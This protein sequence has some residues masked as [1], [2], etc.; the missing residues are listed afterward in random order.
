MKAKTLT[1]GNFK[2][3]GLAKKHLFWIFQLCAA[4]S[5]IGSTITYASVLSQVLPA[6]F[7]DTFGILVGDGILSW[8]IN[9]VALA[10]AIGIAV[11]SDYFFFSVQ[12]RAGLTEFIIMAKRY[13]KEYKARLAAY[14]SSGITFTRCVMAF[15]YMLFGATGFAASFYTSYSSQEIVASV[16]RP[17]AMANKNSK[18]VAD[19]QA[20]MQASE[21]EYT[22]DLSRKIEQR[23][24]DKQAFLNE[25]IN[26]RTKKQIAA[27]NPAALAFADS[28]N[29]VAAKEFD[30]SKEQAELDKAKSTWESQVKPSF[31]KEFSE[32]YQNGTMRNKYADMIGFFVMLLGVGACSG[33]LGIMIVICLDDVDNMPFVV[34]DYVGRKIIRLDKKESKEQSE[35]SAEQPRPSQKTSSP[36]QNGSG[37]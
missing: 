36:K 22:G 11:V 16:A 21:L 9:F 14:Q 19:I 6:S 30:T 15:V 20:R 23:K 28:L 33:M 31:Q 25:N 35:N 17:S 32:V 13:G 2:L 7:E 5:T 26:K 12:F 10:L 4:F 24:K 29:K 34:R 1:I 37:M 18:K 27:R 8:I 3:R